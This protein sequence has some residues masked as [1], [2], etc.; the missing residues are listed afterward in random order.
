MF[1]AKE[2]PIRISGSV[3]PGF[4][5]VREL[6]ESHFRRG[7][8]SNA[9]CCVY[10]EGKRVVDLWGTAVADEGYDADSVQMYFR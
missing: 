3:E 8:E 2:D 10:V 1:K 4:E 5:P 6:F 9:Q 7:L